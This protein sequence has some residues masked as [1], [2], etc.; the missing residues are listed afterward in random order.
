MCGD[1]VITVGRFSARILPDFK[2][3]R[4]QPDSGRTVQTRLAVCGLRF[5]SY[6]LRYYMLEA[7]NCVRRCNSEFKR[8][9][10]L[11]FKGVNKHHHKR[12]PI[13]TARKRVRLVFRLLKDSQHKP[14][15]R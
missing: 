9:Y 8:Y 2:G 11:K 15:E 4:A 1:D 5:G 13:L 14:P 12:I 6:F 3:K 10:N 7:V